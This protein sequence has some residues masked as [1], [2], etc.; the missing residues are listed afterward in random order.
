MTTATVNQKTRQKSFMDL[1]KEEA[2]ARLAKA[3]K[4]AQDELHARSLS[5]IET[6]LST[7]PPISCLIILKYL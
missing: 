7:F 2:E 4:Q 5:D 3:T 1:T 6:M